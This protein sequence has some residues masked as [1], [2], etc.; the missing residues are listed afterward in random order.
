MGLDTDKDFLYLGHDPFG[1]SGRGLAMSLYAVLV[2]RADPELMF[3]VHLD[4][5][6]HRL[7][8]CG[9]V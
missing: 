7:E 6:Q 2:H 8:A 3:F 9:V 1:E 5:A 4:S